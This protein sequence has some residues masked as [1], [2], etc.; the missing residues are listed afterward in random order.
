MN[1]EELRQDFL[2]SIL[3]RLVSVLDYEYRDIVDRILY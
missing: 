2:R 1:K 3:V